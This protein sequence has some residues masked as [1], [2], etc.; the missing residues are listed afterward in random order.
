MDKI[1]TS[2]IGLLSRVIPT[3]YTASQ[4]DSLFLYSGA[5]ETVPEGSKSTKVQNW[6]RK[7]N[8]ESTEPLKI[9]GRIVDDFMVNA[10]PANPY[11]NASDADPEEL[12]KQEKAAI[13]EVLSQEGL[14]YVRGG[15]ILKGG[16]ASTSS[17]LESVRRSGLSSVSIEID[18]ALAQVET[19]PEAAAHYAAN[20]LEAV[21]KVY[22]DKKAVAFANGSTLAELWRLAAEQIG[23]RP[24]DWDSKDLKKIASGLNSIVDGITHLRNNKSGAHGKSEEQARTYA[25]KPRHARLAIHSS[26]TL[27][28]YILELID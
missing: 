12:L 14:A 10:I 8:L 25:V 1:P 9:L 27:A 20:V 21:L 2:L 26:H 13:L 19:D 7:I 6:L 5:P 4:I 24:V 22:L 23:L 15:A 11:W 17:L 18:R 28:A 3:R 16:T